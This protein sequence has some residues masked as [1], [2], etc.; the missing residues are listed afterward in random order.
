MDK[1]GNSDWTKLLLLPA[2][3]GALSRGYFTRTFLCNR[4][5]LLLIA[6]FMSTFGV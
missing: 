6:G 5:V 1:D 3:L 2:H 4:H